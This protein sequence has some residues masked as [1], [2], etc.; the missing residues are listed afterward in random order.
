MA[1]QPAVFLDRDGIINQNRA[2]YVKAWAEFVFLPNVLHD[3]K[4]L[5]GQPVQIVVITNQSAVGRGLLSLHNLTNIHAKMLAEIRHGGGRIDGIYYCP[6]HPDDRCRCRKPEPGMLLQAASELGI[7]LVRSYFIGD[8]V[9]D[10]E[11][12]LRAGCAPLF[13]LTGRGRSQVQ[14]VAERYPNVPIL[15]DLAAAVS[16]IIRNLGSKNLYSGDC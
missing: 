8:A 11:A 14:T 5:A 7:D 4:L 1:K 3:L 13:V 2:D 10:V 12:G 16:L 9:T 15:A 6:H